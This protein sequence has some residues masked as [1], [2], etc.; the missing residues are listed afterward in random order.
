MTTRTQAKT[1]KIFN[2]LKRC[3][4]EERI[5]T[6]TEVGAEVGLIARA[7]ANPHL[8]HIGGECRKR[9]LPQIDALVVRKDDRLPG[10]GFK[11]D[12]TRVTRAEHDEL[13]RKVSAQDWSAVDIPI[14]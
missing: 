7:V 2:Y 5:V 11:P 10:K 13:V 3:A 9:G 8:Y 12:G 4:A 6:Y 14:S 1:L